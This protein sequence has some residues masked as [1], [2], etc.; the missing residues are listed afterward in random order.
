[1]WI[2]GYRSSPENAQNSG[3]SAELL[4]GVDRDYDRERLLAYLDAEVFMEDHTQEPNITDSL[5]MAR[6]ARISYCRNMT[7]FKTWDCHDCADLAVEDFKV[8][9]TFYSASWVV[10]A[11]IGYF[12][13]TNA[14]VISFR[15]G[16]LQLMQMTE[17]IT[18]VVETSLSVFGLIPHLLSGKSVTHWIIQ[19]CS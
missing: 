18:R 14:K 3:R 7:V 8:F 5:P 1:M 12:P 2:C 13:K 9:R 19:S 15:S 16:L 10:F 6:L 4:D 17:T 11:F